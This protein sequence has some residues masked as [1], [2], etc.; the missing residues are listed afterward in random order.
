M[1]IEK[2]YIGQ[3]IKHPQHGLGTVKEITQSTV[4]IQ[5]DDCLRTISPETS[6]IQPSEPTAALDGLEMPLDQLIKQILE[7]TIEALGLEKDDA[8]LDIMG[9]KWHGGRMVLHPFD[10]QLQPKEIPIDT[11]F[12]KIVMAVYASQ[13]L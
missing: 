5:F 9:K 7:S 3:K 1:K 10:A 13:F 12:S 4:Q 6:E 8:I 11:F 2:L